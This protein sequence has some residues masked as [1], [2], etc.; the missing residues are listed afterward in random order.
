M[1]AQGLDTR[2]LSTCAGTGSGPCAG[3]IGVISALLLM[4]ALVLP[5]SALMQAAA[6]SP[7]DAVVSPGDTF[8]ILLQGTYRPVVH[9]PNLGLSQVN[10]SDGSFSTVK[11]YPIS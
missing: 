5:L 7:K 1:N 4:G 10:L 3:H 8:S 2:T 6:P 11:I 9:G